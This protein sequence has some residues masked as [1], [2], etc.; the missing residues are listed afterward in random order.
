M[1]ACELRQQNSPKEV[2]R[3][4]RAVTF[5]R[6]GG[7]EVLEVVDLPEPVPGPGEVRIRVAA[8]TVNPTDVGFRSG[9]Q[10]AQ[11]PPDIR[12]P[13][14]P[15]MELAGTVD[16]VGPGANLQAGQQVMAIV[17]PRRPAGGAMAEE[18]VVPADSVAALPNGASLEQAATLPMNGLTVRLALD[19]MGLQPG[20]FLL[21][22][23]AAGAVGGY[24]VELGVADGLRVIAV[25]S[26]QDEGLMKQMG[27]S[28]FV[29]RGNELPQRVRAAVPGGVDGVVDAALIGPPILSAI[30]DGGRLAAVRGWEGGTERGIEIMQ[31]RVA[32][33]LQNQQALAELG[34]L[35]SDGK[36]TLR[37]AET[38]PPERTGEA[39][40]RL[41]AG[42]VRGRLVIVF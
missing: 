21:V 23:G 7:P 38:Y 32:E 35:A 4:M 27:A 9:R 20:Q 28:L 26:P 3:T 42:G 1:I 30:K 16:M 18:V 15:G 24:A 19:Q 12:P 8:A 31:V 37:V 17:M 10:S 2:K 36:L 29:P 39:Q 34:R 40:E 5:S 41:I 13:Y 33:Y 25:A 14:I 22:T 11:L 6:F